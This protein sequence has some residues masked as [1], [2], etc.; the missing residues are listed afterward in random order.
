MRP[1]GAVLGNW[2][3]ISV[4]V[5]AQDL[6]RVSREK[7][8]ALMVYLVTNASTNHMTKDETEGAEEW[9]TSQAGKRKLG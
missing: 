3:S 6:T 7:C 9:L 5:S 2:T 8:S 4:F 1:P